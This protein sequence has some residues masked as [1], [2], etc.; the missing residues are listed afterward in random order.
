MATGDEKLQYLVEVYVDDFILLA[1]PTS[2]EQLVHIANLIMGVIHDVFP[3]D[4]DGEND[5]LSLKKILK[6]ESMW[7]LHKD[8]LGFTF[9]GMDKEIWLEA[10]TRDVLLTIMKG[11]LQASCKGQHGIPFSKFQSVISKLRHAFISIPN[12]K[13]LL[14]PPCNTILRIEPKFVYLH[15]NKVLRSA[16]ADAQCLLQESTLAPTKYTEFFLG[17]LDFFGV[18]D[19]AKH[20]VGGQIVGKNAACVPTSSV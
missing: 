3:V 16:I 9:D 13:G 14:S 20:G 8:I 17:W 1:V 10:P 19:A 15:R 2:H 4:D 7:A 18:K 12:G 11:W 6:L 5:P